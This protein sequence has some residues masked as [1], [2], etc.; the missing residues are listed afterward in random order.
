MRK[1]ERRDRSPNAPE[2]QPHPPHCVPLSHLCPSVSNGLLLPDPPSHDRPTKVR[3]WIVLG[4]ALASTVAYLSRRC[5]G[6]M[7]TTITDE[8]GWTN[9]QIGQVMGAFNLG[10]FLLQVPTGWLTIRYGTRLVLPVLCVIWSVCSLWGGMAGSFAVFYWARIANGL[11]Q[12]GLVPCSAQAV[13][14]WSPPSTR[15]LASSAIATSMSIGSVIATGLTTQLMPQFGWRGVFAIYA[16]L[17]VLWSLAFYLWFRNRPEEHGAVNTAELDLIRSEHAPPRLTEAAAAVRDLE[18]DDRAAELAPPQPAK[19]GTRVLLLAMVTSSSLWLICGQAFCR[20]YGSEF[21][22]S[23]FPAFLE[24]SHGL[25]VTTAGMLAMLPLIGTV[26]GNA[27]G[28]PLV[29]LILRRTRNKKASRCGTAVA[30]L[31]FSA[32]CTLAAAWA[33]NPV[34]I[35]AVLLLSNFFFGL[36][37]PAA[38]AVAM[39]ISGRHTPIVFGIMNMAGNIGAFLAPVVL[40]MLADHIE[41]T[42]ATWNLM[43]YM[44]AGIYLAGAVCWA[45]LN[46]HRSAVERGP[47]V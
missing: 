7:N 30:A 8:F 39:D 9:T 28:G 46:P 33:G 42:G 21:Y 3:V 47:A 29:D 1:W 16:G 14:A 5:M 10:Y 24:N 45:L 18:R 27:L 19:T 13:Q 25:K 12:A 44:V 26:L 11:A 43:L 37:S 2:P 23:W 31:S 38:W 40:G 15:G 6:V 22:T 35:A 20:A 4:L 17:G 41:R 32:V 34:L 36:G